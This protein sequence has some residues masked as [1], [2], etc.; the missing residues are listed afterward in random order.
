MDDVSRRLALR[1]FCLALPDNSNAAAI[2][3][4]AQLLW[5][6]QYEIEAEIGKNEGPVQNIHLVRVSSACDAG[7][8]A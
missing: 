2:L 1:S 3:V 5:N 8:P 6:H 4:Y 7:W